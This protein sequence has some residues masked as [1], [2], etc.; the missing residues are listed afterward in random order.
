M[1]SDLFISNAPDW[2]LPALIR[3][4]T[5]VREDE[6]NKLDPGL[7]GDESRNSIGTRKTVAINRFIRVAKRVRGGGGTGNAHAVQ[8]AQRDT[9]GP[10][11]AVAARHRTEVFL[12]GCA[13]PIGRTRGWNHSVKRSCTTC[14][15]ALPAE[16][17][18]GRNQVPERP[19]GRRL[20][21]S[22]NM[23][24]SRRG[25]AAPAPENAGDESEALRSAHEGRVSEAPTRYRASPQADARR[26]YG[27]D[28]SAHPLPPPS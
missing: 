23:G 21:Y 27:P 6:R 11:H 24:R 7:S 14:G 17:R 26:R 1:C 20:T 12:S 8:G 5:T 19:E 25:C 28:G 2:V 3:D 16:Y 4:M 22:H 15:S 18:C 10:F 13:R 9:P